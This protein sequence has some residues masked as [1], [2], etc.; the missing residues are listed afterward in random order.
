MWRKLVDE[1]VRWAHRRFWLGWPQLQRLGQGACS[2]VA[3]LLG[4]WLAGQAEHLS[5]PPLLP[6]LTPDSFPRPPACLPCPC[7][8]GFSENL[9]RKGLMFLQTTG[10][11]EYRR[12]RRLV[13]RM[14]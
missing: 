11:F 14:K 3:R 12:E 7:R 8:V 13:H 4:R 6:V 10:D 1:L 5:S 9:V 2:Q